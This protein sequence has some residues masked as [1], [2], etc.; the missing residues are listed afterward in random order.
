MP[1]F[2]EEHSEVVRIGVNDPVEKDTKQFAQ[3]LQESVVMP[4]PQEVGV[5]FQQVQVCVHGFLFIHI[6]L[7]QALFCR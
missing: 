6:H 4:Y 5:R 2:I 1:R 7:A 3:T